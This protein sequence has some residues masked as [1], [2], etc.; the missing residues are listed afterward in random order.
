MD[1]MIPLI[2]CL[3]LSVVLHRRR[4]D[5][6]AVP[7]LQLKNKEY[8]LTFRKKWLKDHPLTESGLEEE[9]EYY[10]SLGISLTFE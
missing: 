4:E 5:I 9:E 8:Q 2:V 1:A 10:E 3:R 6:E 7:K